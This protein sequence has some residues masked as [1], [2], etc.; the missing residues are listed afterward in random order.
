E[1]EWMQPLLELRNELDP[2]RTA[3]AD[4]PL[5]DFRRMNGAV[6]LFNDRPIP[7]PY[8]QEVRSD[9]LRKVLRAQRYICE[10]GPPEVRDLSLITVPELDEIRRIWVIEKHEIEDNLP[11]LYEEVTGERYPGR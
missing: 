1:K 11:G 2:P 9:W 3:Q 7:G 4:R 6:Q 8:K 5:R 10:N